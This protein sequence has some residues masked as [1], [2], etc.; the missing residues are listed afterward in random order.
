MRIGRWE[1]MI[2]GRWRLRFT[3]TDDHYWLCGCYQ[4]G[5]LVIVEW[6]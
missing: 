5:P 4:I 2:V 3:R 1:V 6:A